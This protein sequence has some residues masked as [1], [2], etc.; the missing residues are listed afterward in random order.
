[1]MHGQKNIT[2][3]IICFS[4]YFVQHVLNQYVQ[5]QGSSLSTTIKSFTSYGWYMIAQIVKMGGRG[6]L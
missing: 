5:A 4:F 3:V 1:M 6:S 2:F